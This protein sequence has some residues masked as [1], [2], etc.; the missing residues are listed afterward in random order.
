MTIDSVFRH[1][2]GGR[3]QLTARKSRREK[4][5]GSAEIGERDGG[6]AIREIICFDKRANPKAAT[7]GGEEGVKEDEVEEGEI[8][9]GGEEAPL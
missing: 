9:G 8:V 2:C 5:R 1:C 4:A 3:E 6:G 7:N